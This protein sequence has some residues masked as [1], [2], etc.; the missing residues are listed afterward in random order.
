MSAAE[1]VCSGEGLDA[2]DVLDV[3]ATLVD[4][5]LVAT[6]ERGGEIRYTLHETL[7]AYAQERLA[8]ATEED[9]FRARHLAWTLTF[10]ESQKDA[11]APQFVTHKSTLDRVDLEHDNI[12]QAL[13]CALSIDAT[14]ALRLVAAVGPYWRLRGYIDEG[15]RWMREVLVAAPED[16]DLRLKA[17]VLRL[18]GSLALQQGDVPHGRSLV[19]ESV[20]ISR[21]FGDG[22]SVALG[23]GQLL[24]PAFMYDRDW[25]HAEDLV[26][27]CI[28]IHNE[29]GDDHM[30]SEATMLLAF[31]RARRGDEA[32]ARRL[33]SQAL[34]YNARHPEDP[35]MMLHS[36]AGEIALIQGNLQ[37]GRQHLEQ[38]IAHNRGTGQPL[39]LAGELGWLAEVAFL[40][41]DVNGA[42][43]LL[44]E[45]LS[46]AQEQCIWVWTR[47]ALMW[48]AKVAIHRCDLTS[49]RSNLEEVRLMS[50]MHG[51][52]V[53]PREIELAATLLAAEGRFETAAR[54][55]GAAEAHRDALG[56][57]LPAAYGPELKRLENTL[58]SELGAQTFNEARQGGRQINSEEA[59]ERALANTTRIDVDDAP[60]F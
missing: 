59:V 19:E 13:R 25:S 28:D 10:A 53:D 16:A 14:A 58:R 44:T 21:K 55:L 23:L 11:L 46:T 47:H 37:L 4:R 27:Q 52:V 49:A 8:E 15:R 1:E 57:P 40:E 30:A 24:W 22:Q 51:G 26:Q 33:M 54:M 32:T 36:R 31:V 34:E 9:T 29:G 43:E 38:A 56:E 18:A 41:G 35:C 39:P 12:R 20:A 5:S 42:H 50:R 2:A 7:R 17:V 3:L 48:L 60:A 6:A 45:Q